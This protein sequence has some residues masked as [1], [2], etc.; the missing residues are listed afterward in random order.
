MIWSHSPSELSA[1]SFKNPSFFRPWPD[2]DEVHWLEPV[3]VGRISFRILEQLTSF[4]WFLRGDRNFVHYSHK[5]IFDEDRVLAWID[6]HHCLDLM[7]SNHR[8]AAR[9]RSSWPRINLEDETDLR[10]INAC[11]DLWVEL[12]IKVPQFFSNFSFAS[13]FADGPIDQTKS[14]KT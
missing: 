4:F 7:Q 2:M 10:G 5:Q 3:E 6:L 14:E 12:R 13:A 1:Y 8:Y 9:S 11:A